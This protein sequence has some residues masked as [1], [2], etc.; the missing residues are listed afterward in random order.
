VA[1]DYNEQ[2]IDEFRTNR[3][4]VGGPLAGQDL[5]LVT[6]TGARTGR[7]RTV[8][9]GYYDDVGTAVV[10]AS[11]MGAPTH[12][13]W[14]FNL[15]ANPNVA[16]ERRDAQYAATARVVEGVEREALWSRV[17]EEKAFLAAHQAAAHPREIPLIRLEEL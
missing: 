4:K 3:G 17:V 10:F 13:H 7:I 1:E 9:L 14:Y 15:V 11:A 8:P 16:V 5:V 2:V 6:M 12:P